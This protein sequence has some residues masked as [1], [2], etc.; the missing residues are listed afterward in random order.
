[1]ASYDV[2]G[3]VAFVTG[4]ARGI[5]YE[6]ARLLHARGAAVAMVDH[7]GWS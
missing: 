2:S 4:A 7:S 3:R 1:V 5:G 6:V